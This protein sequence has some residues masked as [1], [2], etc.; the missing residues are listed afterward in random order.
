MKTVLSYLVVILFCAGIASSS[1]AEENAS[2]PPSGFTAITLEEALR[3]ACDRSPL[4]QASLART[5][6]AKAKA[7]AAAFQP[8]LQ[9][10]VSSTWGDPDTKANSLTQDLDIFGQ[11]HRKRRRAEKEYESTRARE[12]ETALDFILRVKTAFLGVLGSVERVKVA[13][14]DVE[15]SRLMHRAAVRRYES[16]DAPRLHVVKAALELT[17]AEKEREDEERGLRSLLVEFNALL[18]GDGNRYAPLEGPSAPGEIP[19]VEDLKKRALASR[20]YLRQAAAALEEARESVRIAKGDYSPWVQASAY[21]SSFEAPRER[22]VSLSLIIPLSDWGARKAQVAA[23]RSQQDVQ[24]SLARQALIDVMLQ[25]EEA[26]V[27]TQSRLAQL[28]MY[29][30]GVME[31]TRELLMMNQKGYEKGA[32]GY[33]EVIEARKSFKQVRLEHQEVGTGLMVALAR[34]ERVVGEDAITKGDE[35][36]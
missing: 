11:L 24:E 36:K 29:E 21:Q 3:K 32:L 22:G 12:E 31:S 33:I 35:R 2:S 26:Y 30:S 19:P 13:G 5:R 8:P 14:E 6:L 7:G 34:L 27:E 20:P 28:R 17:R 15:F 16:G 25:V 23:A 18:G 9:A 10:T 4:L 1:F